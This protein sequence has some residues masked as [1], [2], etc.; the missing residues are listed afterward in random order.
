MNLIGNAVKFTGAGSVRVLCSVDAPP[1]GSYKEVS[2]KFE[3]AC[4]QLPC[5]PYFHFSDVAYSDTGIG[6]SATE[7]DLLFVP[8]QQADVRKF[9]LCL[10]NKVTRYQK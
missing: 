10:T 3:I 8:F 1:E 2:L 7:I 5:L 6:L 4:V 9:I